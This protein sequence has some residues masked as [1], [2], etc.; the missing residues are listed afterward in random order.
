MLWDYYLGE[1]LRYGPPYDLEVSELEA[2]MEQ[3]EGEAATSQSGG[4][5]LTYGYDN[6]EVEHRDSV[7]HMLGQIERLETELGY[8]PRR[9]SHHWSGLEP[10]P[11][12]PPPPPPQVLLLLLL[13]DLPV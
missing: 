7:S 3:E 11:P 5:N 1:E 9:W 13:L 6:L 12:H 10:P 8:L 4:L 2:A